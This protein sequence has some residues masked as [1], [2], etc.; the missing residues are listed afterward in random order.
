MNILHIITYTV[1]S[2]NEVGLRHEY[3]TTIDRPYWLKTRGI[4]RM[5]RKSFGPDAVVNRVGTMINER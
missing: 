5:I 3:T 1:P 2:I 4:E